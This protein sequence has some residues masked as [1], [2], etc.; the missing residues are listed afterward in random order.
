MATSDAWSQAERG[1][2][3][4]DGTPAKWREYEKRALMLVAKLKLQTKQK[5]AGLLL[6]TGLTGDAWT[7]I[8]LL[9]VSE[10][11]GDDSGQKVID[12]LR[13]RFARK[14]K[15]QLSEDFE[16]FFIDFRRQKGER[17]SAYIA[18]FRVAERKVTEHKIN[19]PDQVQS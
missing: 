9:D 3:L 11:N 12:V 15:T 1:T 16:R 6:A 4:F 18:R 5:E 10:L 2:P 8:D 7:E 13:A 19:L 14:L 17:L